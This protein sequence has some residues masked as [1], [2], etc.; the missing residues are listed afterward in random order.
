MKRRSFESK[1]RFSNKKASRKNSLL[2]SVLLQ[3]STVVKP[4]MR[5][6]YPKEFYFH[7]CGSQKM[8]FS[9]VSKVQNFASHFLTPKKDKFKN[10]L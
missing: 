5:R 1:V 9:D 3:K 10:V 7:A 6:F 4:K 2:E 8:A